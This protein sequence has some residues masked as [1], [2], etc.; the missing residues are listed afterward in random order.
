MIYS[1]G[2]SKSINVETSTLI[3]YNKYFLFKACNAPF[4]L[5]LLWIELYHIVC[6][7]M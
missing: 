5:R 2:F 1:H 3:T 6:D 4:V 7:K